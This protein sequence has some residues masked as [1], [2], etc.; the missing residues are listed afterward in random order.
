MTRHDLPTGIPCAVCHWTVYRWF[1]LNG[2]KVA[3]CGH[4]EGEILESAETAA[5]VGFG[6][7]VES[8]AA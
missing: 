8:E 1:E 4:T 3:D 6:E 5:R 2:Q 7:Y